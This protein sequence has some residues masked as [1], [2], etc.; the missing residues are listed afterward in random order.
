MICLG[1][2]TTFLPCVT[3]PPSA[4][5]LG[6]PAASATEATPRATTTLSN[7]T[8]RRITAP[9]IPAARRAEQLLDRY[10]PRCLGEEALVGGVLQQA[11]DQVGHPGHEVADG[12]VGAH[13]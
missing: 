5:T 3:V 4:R 7:D 2:T 12:T 1:R 11:P 6:R 9:N 10:S 13:P 8:P